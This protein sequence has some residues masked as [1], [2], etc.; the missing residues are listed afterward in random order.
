MPEFKSQGCLGAKVTAAAGA[1]K[2]TWS[3]QEVLLQAEGKY[4][5][6]LA[7]FL[8]LISNLP[9]P[10]LLKSLQEVG[11]LRS[12]SGRR[13]EMG[14]RLDRQVLQ[15]LYNLASPAVETREN[16]GAPGRHFPPIWCAL[17]MC[18]ALVQGRGKA[19][20]LCPRVAN[21]Y[22]ILKLANC[23]A[24]KQSEDD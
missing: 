3:L 16:V 9:L 24:E 14:L 20:E 17:T 23:L 6:C 12:R 4:E 8:L 10:I 15:T 13:W 22:S 19:G 21:K 5:D 18:Q 11:T 2:K 7:S 1:Q